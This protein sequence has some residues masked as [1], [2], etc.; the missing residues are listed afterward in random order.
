MTIQSHEFKAA[1][2][3]PD[4]WLFDCDGTI[5]GEEYMPFAV[6][7]TL[8]RFLGDRYDHA[9]FEKVFEVHKGGGFAKYLGNYKE[10]ARSAGED[11]TNYPTESVFA[12]AAVMYY[13]MILQALRKNPNQ[14]LFVIRPGMVEAMQYVAYQDEPLAITTNARRAIVR[15]NMEA[16]GIYVKGEE[17]PE[18][19]TP[20]VLIDACV[21]LEDYVEAAKEKGVDWKTL[22]KPDGFPYELT[23][24]IL[25]KKL[26]EREGREITIL[27]ERCVGF[28]DST[29]GHKSLADAGVGVRVHMGNDPIAG[30]FSFKAG[31]GYRMADAVVSAHGMG[32]GVIDD[33]MAFYQEKVLKRG[34]MMMQKTPDNDLLLQSVPVF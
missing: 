26:S 13:R 31:D 16:A 28:E 4:A 10:A 8:S 33:L 15:A 14:K 1:N 18:G 23:C 3:K 5:T 25:S 27:P 30:I 9:R 7:F 29:N 22:I 11:V 24:E 32:P 2:N 17:I 19:I 21:C 20:K 12:A 34:S 6:G